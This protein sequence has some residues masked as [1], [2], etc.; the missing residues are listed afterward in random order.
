M[1]GLGPA[2]HE[3]IQKSKDMDV[4]DKRGVTATLGASFPD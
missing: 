2:I 4:R 1:A 3:F